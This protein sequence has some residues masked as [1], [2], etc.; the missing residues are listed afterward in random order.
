VG[1]ERERKQQATHWMEQVGLP[2]SAAARPALEFSGGERQ[3][4][5]IARSLISHP[6]MI[7][8]DEPF[9]ALDLPVAT[10][11]LN[12][13]GRLRA[14]HGLTYLFIGHDLTMLA[15]VCS[16]VVVMCGGR[17]VER[18]AIEHVISSPAHFY[19]QELVRAIPR[20]PAEW[21]A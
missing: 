15:R 3:R 6:E 2:A 12:L 21:L 8:F 17:I 18:G 19:S 11:L 14:S 16:E 5:A 7:I 13:L 1:N 10:R 4:L 9:S 20:V